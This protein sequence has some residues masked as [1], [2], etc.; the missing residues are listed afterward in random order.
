MDEVQNKALATTSIITGAR[1]IKVTCLLACEPNVLIMLQP[2]RLA[3]SLTRSVIA[4]ETS[5]TSD[6]SEG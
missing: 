5:K 4:N 3:R 1:V 6:A 2:L